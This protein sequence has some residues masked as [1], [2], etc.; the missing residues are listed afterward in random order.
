MN[1]TIVTSSHK[2]DVESVE[3]GKQA[4]MA[5]NTVFVDR[6]RMSLSVLREK[7]MCQNVIVVKNGEFTLHTLSGEY[8]FHPSMSVPRIKSLKEGKTDHM[9]EAMS[10]EPGDSVLDCTLGLGA[11]AIVASFTT[12]PLGKVIG[13]E[14]SA[15]IAFLVKYGFS[16]YNERRP[17]V[18]EAMSRISVINADY[19][20]YL[21]AQEDNSFDIVYFDPMFRFPR[22]N[23]SSMRPLRE[24]VNPE[25][26]NPDAITHA[27]RVARK[28]VILKENWF[29]TEFQKLGFNKMGG[30]KYS[31]VAFGIIEKQEADK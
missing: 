7:Y 21:S 12:G 6:E 1:R 29:S 4:A 17:D 3:Q 15:E 27:I 22:K 8:F 14:H 9:V 23:S 11:D 10:L 2:P 13:I 16:H 18:K 30:G 25:P 31:P 26:L 28:R 20:D 19:T 5:L 24:V